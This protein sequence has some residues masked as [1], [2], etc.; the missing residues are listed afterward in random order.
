MWW[1]LV[2]CDGSSELRESGLETFN[3]VYGKSSVV[4]DSICHRFM[5]TVETVAMWYCGS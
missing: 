1:L 4:I 5:E 2:G 3:G